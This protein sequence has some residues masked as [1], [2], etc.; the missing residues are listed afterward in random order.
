MS[1]KINNTKLLFLYR[2]CLFRFCS[3]YSDNN[4]LREIVMALNIKNRRE[5]ITYVFDEAISVLNNYYS[6]DL[7]QFKDGKCIVQREKNIDRVNG[8]CRLCPIVTDKGCPSV[9]IMCKLIYCKRALG[10]IKLLKMSDI[11]IL[12]CLSPIQRLIILS[13]TFNTRE[14]VIKDLYYG[15]FYSVPRG[16]FKELRH[17]VYRLKYRNKL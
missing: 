6:D 9:N 10:N 7:C 4:D 11:K 8:C 13:D 14:E 16:L 3:F 5:R 17:F 12:K 15:P 1:I 2:S